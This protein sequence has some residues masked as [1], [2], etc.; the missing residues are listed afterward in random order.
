MLYL[1]L[2]WS[3]AQIGLFSF[4]GGYAA[5]PIIQK[6]VVS[7]HHWLTLQEFM[8][9]LA[10]SQMTPGPV[11]INTSTFV[12]MRIL[13]IPG[14]ITATLGCVVPSFV[15]VLII[16]YFYHKY[17]NIWV[18]QGLL[19]GLRPATVSLIGASGLGI[20][21]AA[22]YHVEI[23]AFAFKNIASLDIPAAVTFILGMFLLGKRRSD[24]IY[25]IIGAGLLG[26]IFA[27][28]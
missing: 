16:A 13:G 22:L 23:E 18:M 21:I 7:L 24:P 10:I 15:I 9:I 8:D 20:L 2:F 6:Q 26:M 19:A 1:Q 5:L 27:L 4:G 3:F 14:A 11:A 25:I 17:K 12:G 28:F